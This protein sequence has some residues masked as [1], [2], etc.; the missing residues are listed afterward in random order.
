MVFIFQCHVE[1]DLATD[2]PLTRIGLL[3]CPLRALD[4]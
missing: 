1:V 3:L 2:L 4:A